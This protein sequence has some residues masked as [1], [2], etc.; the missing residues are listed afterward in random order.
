[1]KKTYR[2]LFSTIVV[3]SILINV[4][5]L[6]VDIIPTLNEK[7]S[8]HKYFTNEDPEYIERKIVDAGYKMFLSPKTLMPWREHSNFMSKVKN[9]NAHRKDNIYGFP[10]GFLGL[11]L[12]DYSIKKDTLLLGKVKKQFDEYYINEKGFNF[13]INIVDQVPIG[14]S[15]LKL[16]R[17]YKEQKYKAA[18]DSTYLFIKSQIYIKDNKSIVLYRLSNKDEYNPQMLVDVLGMICPFLMEYGQQFN[19][20]ESL[21]LSLSELSFFIDNGLESKSSLPFHSINLKTNLSF[22]PNNWGRGLGWYM[23]A[24]SSIYKNTDHQS[25]KHRKIEETSQ[26]F[27]HT[28]SQ[29]KFKGTF[30]QFPGTSLKFDSSASTMLIYGECLINP[31]SHTKQNIIDIFRPSIRTNGAIDF[32]SGDTYNVNVYSHEF[33]LSELSQGVLILLLSLY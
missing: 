26:L 6:A 31:K 11:G 15:A 17:H 30:S 18:A 20:K 13:N 4:L 33:G 7:I 29:L 16:F 32:C 25:D 19:N 24:L 8:K 9:L 2:F 3:I 22:G 28:L 10:R 5:L 12:I 27:L 23:F 14:L 21:E 1:M